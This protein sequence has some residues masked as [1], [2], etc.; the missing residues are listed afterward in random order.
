MQKTY[1]DIVAIDRT[2]H[3]EE[4]DTICLQSRAQHWQQIGGRWFIIYG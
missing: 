2:V 3:Y 1:D 4:V